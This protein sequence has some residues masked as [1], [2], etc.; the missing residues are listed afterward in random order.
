MMRS[1][2]LLCSRSAPRGPKLPL[3]LLNNEVLVVLLLSYSISINSIIISSMIMCITI[4]SIMS[5]ISL[6]QTLAAPTCGEREERPSRRLTIL[7]Q[8]YI[9]IYRERERKRDVFICSRRRTIL[10]R[11]CSS[12]SS[13]TELYPKP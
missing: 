10:T 2:L 7:T 5:Y 8:L 3:W 1:A 9:Y 4:L 13:R 6:I 11:P 12:S